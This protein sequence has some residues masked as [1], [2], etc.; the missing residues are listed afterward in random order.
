ML[1]Y[2]WKRLGF[3]LGSRKRLDSERPRFTFLA[4][5]SRLLE[6]ISITQIKADA[7]APMTKYAI[8]K[9]AAIVMLI[10]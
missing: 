3:V 4:L 9:I 1:P 6:A 2:G 5:F 7:N 10:P 8:I